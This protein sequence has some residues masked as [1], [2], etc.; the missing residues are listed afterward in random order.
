VRWF[1]TW[2]PMA[3][4]ARRAADSLKTGD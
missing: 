1:T 4:V 3:Q 2:R